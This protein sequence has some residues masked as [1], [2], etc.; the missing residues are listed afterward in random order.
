MTITADRTTTEVPIILTIVGA[1]GAVTTATAVEAQILDANTVNSFLDFNDDTFKTSG[2]TDIDLALAHQGSGH[3][4]AATGLDISAITNLPS[5]TDVL[6][7]LYNYTLD[8][9]TYNASEFIELN[10]PE[11]VADQVWDEAISGHAVAGSTGQALDDVLDDTAAIQPNIDAAIS[12]RAT[13]AQ[14]LSD[15]TPFQGANVAA[16]LTDTAA[17]QPTVATNLNATITSRAVAGDAMDLVAGAVDAAAVA[18]DAID[19]DALAADAASEI[20]TAVGAPTAAAVADAVWDEATAGHVAAGSTAVALTD[21]LADTA[22]MQPT[23][24][25]NLNATISSVNTA[26][27]ALNDP[28]ALAIAA[29]VAGFDLSTELTAGSLSAGIARLYGGNT[30]TRVYFATSAISNANRVVPAGAIS[31]MEVNVRDEGGAFAG[32]ETYFVVFSYTATATSSDA[33]AAST[34]TD[35]APADGTFDAVVAFPT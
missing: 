34:R 8:G 12:T 10:G 16:I 31:H 18:T 33:P 27:A 7:V 35:A 19:A 26:I 1:G 25:T 9:N 23:I 24:A 2:H 32:T 21:V 5:G 28:T 30:R 29:A 6:L 17:M 15:A 20:A 13:Q 3:Y 11:A 14:I 22:A 4:Q